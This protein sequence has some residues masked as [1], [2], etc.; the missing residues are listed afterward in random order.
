M[1][2]NL[3]SRQFDESWGHLLVPTEREESQDEQRFPD[4]RSHQH[5]TLHGGKLEKDPAQCGHLSVC[6]LM[7]MIFK[8]DYFLQVPPPPPPRR[9]RRQ[10]AKPLN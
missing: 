1:C 7:S 9:G 3:A 4:P 2:Q 10:L 6:E 5:P 8:L